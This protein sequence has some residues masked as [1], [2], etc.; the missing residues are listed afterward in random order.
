MPLTCLVEDPCNFN[1]S[2]NSQNKNTAPSM[3]NST[4][5]YSRSHVNNCNRH[6]GCGDRDGGGDNDATN[7]NSNG[8]DKYNCNETS[9]RNNKND[10]SSKMESGQTAVHGAVSALLKYLHSPSFSLPLP[11][12]SHLPVPPHVPHLSSSST[13]ESIGDVHMNRNAPRDVDRNTDSRGGVGRDKGRD[14]GSGRGREENALSRT[15]ALFTDNMHHPLSGHIT[16]S[17]SSLLPHIPVLCFDSES[18]CLPSD[19]SLLSTKDVPNSNQI[20]NHQ[21]DHRYS[22]SSSEQSSEFNTKFRELFDTK[23]DSLN[24]QRWRLPHSAPTPSSTSIPPSS[25]TSA[26]ISIPVNSTT[27]IGTVIASDIAV[28]ASSSAKPSTARNTSDLSAVQNPLN[29][30]GVQNTLNLSGVDNTTHSN[31]SGAP[32]DRL[33]TSTFYPQNKYRNSGSGV[34]DWSVIEAVLDL[35]SSQEILDLDSRISRDNS[36]DVI[37]SLIA[38]TMSPREALR[39]SSE[40]M[41]KFSSVPPPSSSSSSSSLPVSGFFGVASSADTTHCTSIPASKN[42]N[43]NEMNNGNNENTSTCPVKEYLM[44]SDLARH[45]CHK[46]MQQGGLIVTQTVVNS[47]IISGMMIVT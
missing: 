34:V 5:T 22:K 46:I 40:T 41:D 25:S 32:H 29:L 6:Q 37:T 13:V 2:F 31:S 7:C 12:P 39:I 30:S 27:F 4:Y 45:A 24:S 3:R 17:I 1:C 15:Y 23:C 26:P 16:T 8:N 33:H 19:I 14:G 20:P 28:S 42:G 38:G 11:I 21:I 9:D 18:V 36:D 44:T 35:Q 10:D 47:G 43:N